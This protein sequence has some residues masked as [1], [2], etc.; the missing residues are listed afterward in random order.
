MD[1]KISIKL[2]FSIGM[3]CTLPLT[4][5][6]VGLGKMTVKSGLGQP[7]RAE[8]ELVA[9]Q[10]GELDT[11]AARIASADAFRQSQI[12][13]A[14]ALSQIRFSVDPKGRGGPV[15][16]LTS[17]QPIN[18]PFLAML[19]ELDW[20]TGRLVREYTV[21]LDPPGF[22]AQQPIAPIATS[23]ADES[24]S[25]AE[26]RASRREAAKSAAAENPAESAAPASE[27]ANRDSYGPVKKGES[28]AAIAAKTKPQGASLDQMLLALY[29]AN[30]KAFEGGNM[31]RLRRGQV[32]QVPAESAVLSA[33]ASEAAREVKV[34]AADWSA[35]R[36]RL[37][38]AAAGQKSA[39][40]GT[41]GQAASGKITTSVED[42]AAAERPATRD[43]LKL[44]KGETAV[45]G[46]T[47][48]TGTSKDAQALRDRINALQEDAIA[49]DK[50]I[51]EANSRI[52]DLE[53]SIKEMQRLLEIKNQ[54]L[55]QL[56]KQAAAPAPATV[57]PVAPAPNAAK[58]TPKPAVAT[59]AEPAPAQT[60]AP[61]PI[62]KAVPEQPKTSAPNPAAAAAKPA[63]TESTIPAKPGAKGPAVVAA[64]SEPGL[65]ERVLSNP[66]YLSAGLVAILLALIGALVAINH[67]RKKRL[68]S[69][70]DSILTGGDLKA[71]T[72][73][74][75][76][77]GGAIDTGDTSFLT[78]FS[79]AGM[80]SIDTN[81]VDPIAEAEVYM[82]YGRDAQAEEILKEAMKKDPNRHDIHLKL[83]EIYAA[84]K[85]TVAFET[86]A[87]ELYASLGG[88]A[89]PL[90]DKAAE[91][92]RG[93]DP[94]NPL[95]QEGGTPASVSAE[96]RLVGE[97][98]ILPLAK[99][100]AVASDEH[101]M[102]MDSDLDF[103]LDMQDLPAD[104]RGLSAAPSAPS[105]SATDPE[106][107][108]TLTE[109]KD[110]APAGAAHAAN[111]E[112][113]ALHDAHEEDDLDLGKEPDFGA[114]DFTLEDDLA[115]PASNPDTII[116][117]A[118][119]KQA[120]QGDEHIEAEKASPEV[121][122]MDLD[123]DY[124]D[125]LAE[126]DGVRRDTDEIEVQHVNEEAEQ[127]LEDDMALDFDFDLDAPDTA[128][129]DE[130][131][132][133]NTTLPDLDFSNINLD[134]D[135]E[136]TILQAPEDDE[137][138]APG[139]WEE[140]AT[141]LDLAKAYV[142]MGD[143]EGAREIL[144]EVLQEGGPKQQEDAKSLLAAL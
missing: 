25:A 34:Q 39:E 116:H 85:N 76:T 36:N 140:V 135:D 41:A 23:V 75:N 13:R 87:S 138:A 20:P 131:A 128:A 79:Q 73:F 54:N 72:V 31:N 45:A 132:P 82:A 133:A 86:L 84:R 2:L 107:A 17:S 91:M 101:S 43:V 28:L 3:L 9:V 58:P 42:K 16:K 46:G 94:N 90:W 114:L 71:N 122:R 35:Y 119:E 24:K 22:G 26:P 144:Q 81:D 32:L 6:A 127:K 130:R 108:Q 62:V 7:L 44:S 120:S 83:L 57:A 51:Q 142:E 98:S 37:A 141:K 111:A 8:I 100:N 103:G 118:V 29:R 50:T 125:A 92:G 77:L 68:A 136:P 59:P 106:T 123:L 61:A 117:Q 113:N 115:E 109:R 67:N 27:R 48:A 89:G 56:Q 64:G 55:A 95:Y 47:A 110:P 33:G 134:M 66:M 96:S 78:D 65:V 102:D 97:D 11:L 74:G 112:P 88:K 1:R 104:R 10:K 49:K 63:A 139:E 69:F 93:I 19:V 99:R 21:L 12:D 129:E 137:V 40:S 52:G 15:L 105:G 121:E 60:P 70:E 14:A 4:A 124:D 80:G 143:K 5:S 18:E 53:K 30:P 38:N 126:T